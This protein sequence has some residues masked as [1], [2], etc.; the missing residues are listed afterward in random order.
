MNHH[1]NARLTAHGRELLVTQI[2]EQGQ[3][4]TDAARTLGVS[5]HTVHK[6]LKR[7]R[8][9]GKAGLHNRSSRPLHSPRT[10]DPAVGEAAAE[11]RRRRQTYQQIAQALGVS[12]STV[13]RVLKKR[14]LNRLSALEPAPRRRAKIEKRRRACEKITGEAPDARK[15]DMRLVK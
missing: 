8:E 12:T 2:I 13:G 10:T 14:G 11:L 7:Y 4:P 1:R 9:E 6:W 5:R 15:R 3:S